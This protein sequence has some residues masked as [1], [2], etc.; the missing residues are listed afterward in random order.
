LSVIQNSLSSLLSYLVCFSFKVSSVHLPLFLLLSTSRSAYFKRQ[1]VCL[2][3]C[4]RPYHVE[5]TSSRPITEVKQHW[6]RIVLGWETAWEHRVLLAFFFGHSLRILCR[7]FFPI[8]F[9]SR[10]KPASSLSAPS[11]FSVTLE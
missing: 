4:Q 6:A 7:L 2:L 9:V 5:H 1:N 10:S 11:S 8:L 3:P